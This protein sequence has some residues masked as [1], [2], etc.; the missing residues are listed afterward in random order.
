MYREAPH[1]G[2]ARIRGGLTHRSHL[3][4]IRDRADLVLRPSDGHLLFRGTAS[5]VE[6]AQA[7]RT[8]VDHIADLASASAGRR[9]FDYESL[10]EDW[11]NALGLGAAIALVPRAALAQTDHSAAP[12]IEASP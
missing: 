10:L 5:S 1:L 2:D 6:T 3:L 12:A 4:L 8:L 11:A 7:L 9:R